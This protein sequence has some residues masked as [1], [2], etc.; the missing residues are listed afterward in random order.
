ELSR[1]RSLFVIARNSSFH[2]KGQSPKVQRVGRELGVE[3]VV[4]GSVRRAGDRVRISAQLVEAASGNHLWAER[5]DYELED[6]FAVQDEVTQAIASILP[7]KLDDDAVARAKR[8]PP[9][10][11][12]AYDY[13]LRGE[14][15][16]HADYGDPRARAMFEKAIELDSDC[17]RAHA[18]L[19]VIELY[20][21]FAGT[22]AERSTLLARDHID[23]ALGVD[24]GDSSVHWAA[25][26]AY[27]L[28]GQHDRARLHAD[29][30]IALN[31]NDVDAIHTHGFVKAYLGDAVGGLEWMARARR[32]D[33]YQPQAYVEDW[34]EAYYMSGQY[35]KA[36]E[37]FQGWHKPPFQIYK[38]LAACYAQLDRMDEAQT[39]L[40]EY[41]QQR[42]EGHDLAKATA[43]HMRMCARQKDRDHWLEGFRKAR[44]RV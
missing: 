31:P 4:E 40:A 24:E 7:R 25:A 41:E 28:L 32:L 15:Y 9:Y 34:L 44:L 30:A 33:P 8:K 37:A 26:L 2:Y 19:A 38:N 10:N 21:V 39:A 20:K 13:F 3:Y 43:A 14:S 6:I 42:P 1:Y 22:A 17:V 29:R 11:L 35:E 36:I 5:Y 23:R 18:R 27:L 16:I 12:T